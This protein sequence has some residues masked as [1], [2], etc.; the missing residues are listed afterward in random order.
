MQSDIDD[1]SDDDEVEVV[2]PDNEPEPEF[3]PEPDDVEPDNDGVELEMAVETVET[4]N[5]PGNSDDTADDSDNL[6]SK[7][8]IQWRRRGQDVDFPT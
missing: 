8:D 4:D 2:P 5:D 3:E 1:I 7:K 6:T